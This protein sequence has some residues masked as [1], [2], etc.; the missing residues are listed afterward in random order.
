MHTYGTLCKVSSTRMQCLNS[1]SIWVWLL[2]LHTARDH[3]FM[4]RSARKLI[5]SR[6]REAQR[7]GVSTVILKINANT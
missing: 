1:V 3:S 7:V 2:V 4:H 5:Y 6:G